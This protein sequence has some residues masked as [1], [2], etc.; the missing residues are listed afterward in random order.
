MMNLAAS[1]I[2]A[3]RTIQRNG[4]RM[5]S[6]AQ[7]CEASERVRDALLEYRDAH[8]S[9][10]LPSRFKKEVLRPYIGPNGA[11]H[12]EEVNALLKNIGHPQDIL[13]EQEQIE[14][15]EAA[16]SKNRS[17]SVKKMLEL[18]D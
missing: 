1:R 14:L 18:L 5:F 9:R 6:G 15:L 11:V 8:Y 12:I 2:I 10:E 3:T 17:I 13:S 7:T 16:G 4:M